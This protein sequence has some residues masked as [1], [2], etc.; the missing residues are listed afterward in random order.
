MN[1]IHKKQILIL[2]CFYKPFGGGA[3]VYIEEIVKKLKND[4]D[5]IILT[6][7]ISRKFPRHEEKDGVRIIRIG[8]G[9]YFD[10]YLYPIVAFF[11]IFSIEKDLI[12][13]V[14]ESYAGL[15]LLSY[16]IIDRNTPA[17][18]TLQSGRVRMPKFLFKK[19]HQA[20]D[21]IQAISKY[22][23][24]RAKNFG[25]KNIEVIPNGINL[26]QFNP[27]LRDK[28]KHK[29]ICVAHLRRVKGI[30]YLIS[31]MPKILEKFPDAKLILIGEGPEKKDL[32]SRIKNQEL[33]DAVE[34]KGKLS[35]EQVMG[36]LSEAEVFVLPSLFEG[37]GI[38]ILEAQAS[39]VPVIASD[40]GG[41]PDI[42]EDEKT[43][44]LVEPKNSEQIAGA[45]IKIFLY[46]N[47]AKVLAQNALQEVQQYDWQNIAQE[48]NKIYQQLLKQR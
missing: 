26:E 42:V 17:L 1:E 32:E 34:L 41:I 36:E 3:E 15:A 48:I 23:A 40:I 39:N 27:A 8:I 31:A 22:L 18:L 20:P 5:F 4:Y 7:R 33:R 19:I 13:A 47:L 16:R 12:H 35:Q 6:S 43:G 28:Q 46:P 25:A 9:C 30:R 44:I 11:K 10:K 21:K 38:A 29:I 2:S 45:I 24:Q 37:Q 14:M